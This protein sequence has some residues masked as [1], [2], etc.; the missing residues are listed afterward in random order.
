MEWESIDYPDVDVRYAALIKLT[1]TMCEQ[2]LY[3]AKLTECKL[4][5]NEYYPE[6]DSTQP[7]GVSRK[8]SRL[9][10]SIFF[11]RSKSCFL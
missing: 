3:Y 9:E 2:C 11:N 10:F 8:V 6:F 4:S 7:F 1:N 5:Q